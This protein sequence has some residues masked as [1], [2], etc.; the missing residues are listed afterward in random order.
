VSP[1]TFDRVLVDLTMP[2][3]TGTELAKKLMEILSDILSTGFSEVI[4][5]HGV[6]SLG[7]RDA[8]TKPSYAIELKT[9]VRRVLES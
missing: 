9:A 2:G 1:D 7:I 3:L 5:A 6:K 8:I 4:D